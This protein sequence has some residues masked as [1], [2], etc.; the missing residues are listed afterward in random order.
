MWD[1]NSPLF[2][3]GI[4]C[5]LAAIVGGG[6]K[7]MGSE[8]PV[9]NSWRRQ[10]LLALFGVILIA[11]PQITMRMGEFRVTKVTVAWDGD[12]YT[13]CNVH[14]LFTASITIAGGAGD[15]ESRSLVVGTYASS[16]ITHVDGAGVHIIH[17]WGDANLQPGS[18]GEYPVVV[19]VLSPQQLRSDPNYLHVDC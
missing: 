1:V 7:A 9:I 8:L 18:S 19:E 3:L 2:I 12:H 13:G 10:M 15:F 16:V 17:G 5:L 14:A 4:V 11:I 6:V